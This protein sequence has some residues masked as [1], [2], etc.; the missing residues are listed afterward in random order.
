MLQICD[1]RAAYI[2]VAPSLQIK[3]VRNTDSNQ[4]WRIV[5]DNGKSLH[6][7][8]LSN[9]YTSQSEENIASHIKRLIQPTSIE[10]TPIES[11]LIDPTPIEIDECLPYSEWYKGDNS[12]VLRFEIIRGNAEMEFINFT[13]VPETLTFY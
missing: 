2:I 4:K 1:I 12:A 11:P 9:N 8:S 7:S 6:R 5:I 3:M 10:P 13:P